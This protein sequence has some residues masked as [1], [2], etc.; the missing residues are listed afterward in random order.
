MKTVN[1]FVDM[2]SEVVKGSETRTEE[3]S[4]RAEDELESDKSKKQKIDEHV[5]AEKD[6][7]PEEEEMKKHME[8]VQDE[9]EIAIDDIPLATKP[10]MIVEYK[11]VKEGQKGFYH[12]IRA[13][14]SSKRYSLMIRMLQGIH[15]EDLETLWKLVKEKHGINR[16]VDE[17][18][19]VLWGDLKVMFE[20]ELRVMYGEIYKGTKYPLTPITISNMLNKKLQADHW[21]EMCYQLLKLMTKQEKVNVACAQLQL[22][23]DYY[24][25]KEYADRDEIKDWLENKNTYED[26][27]YLFIKKLESLFEAWTRFKD[28]LQKVPHHG[29]DLWL[30][31]QIFYDH[32]NPITRRTI[33]QAAGE[34]LRDKNDKESWAL[35]EELA[36]YDNE[37]WNDPRDFAKPVNAVSMPQ[38]VPMNKIASSCEICSGPHDTQICMEN[39]EQAF[40]EYASSRTDE[41]EVSGTLSSPSKI[42]LVTP[43]IRHGKV[44]QTLGG[45]NLTQNNFSNLPNRLQSNGLFTNRS[46]NNNPQ[47][48]NQ[49]NLEGLVS[50][51]MASQDAKI[52]R[53]KADFQQHQSQ[54]TNKLDTLLKAFNDRMTG[55]LPSDTIKNP[56]LNPNLTSSARSY[57]T[58]DPQINEIETPKPKEPEKSLEDEFENL[59]LN[60]PVLEVLAHIPIYDTLLDKNIVNLE[61]GRNGY[62]FIQSIAPEKMK[63]HELF[64]LPCKLGDSKP[65]DTLGD[66]GSCMNLIPLNLFKKLKIGLL[67]ETEDVLRLKH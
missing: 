61:L 36:L 66:L 17:Y 13:D 32:V 23:S 54:I 38:D 29:I 14:G 28:L 64:I 42:T 3:S 47:N 2:N 52:T 57:P 16:L 27:Y 33:D 44:T 60:L 53:F 25:W 40:I 6:D 11:I 1:N 7:D 37:S 18:E 19:R 46:F 35:L 9:E 56:K 65:F 63:D 43:I 62:E 58:D 50:N 4:K 24:C 10:P 48:F 41:A 31:I 51:F 26:K 12:L 55:A 30:Q 8:I 21:N 45:G 59:H 20:P 22:L 67:E 15:R 49:T 39:P 5:E 34:K